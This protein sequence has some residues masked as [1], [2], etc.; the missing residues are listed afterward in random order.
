[1]QIYWHKNFRK[2]YNK[3]DTNKKH[4]VEKALSTFIEN[5]NATQLRNHA[6]KGNYKDCRSI[7]AAFDLRIIFYQ[8]K[9]YFIV[10][11]LKIGTHSQL[12]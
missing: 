11:L 12:Y 10:T 1:M 7:D 3:L 9:N 4:L 6:L 2:Q 8:E 5:P